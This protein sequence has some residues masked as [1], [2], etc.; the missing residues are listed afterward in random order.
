MPER[1]KTCPESSAQGYA[2]AN[3]LRLKRRAAVAGAG[4]LDPEVNHGM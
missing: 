4:P 3:G 1:L 2:G